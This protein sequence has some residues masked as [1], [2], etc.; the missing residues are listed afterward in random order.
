MPIFLARMLLKHYT[1]SDSRTE[2]GAAFNDCLIF[3]IFLQPTAIS[4][5]SSLFNNCGANMKG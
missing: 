4:N 5:R 3:D 1:M 2:R